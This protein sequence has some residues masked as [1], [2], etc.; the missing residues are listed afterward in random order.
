MY[1][2]AGWWVMYTDRRK[3]AC[4]ALEEDFYT[5][6]YKGWTYVADGRCEEMDA[7]ARLFNGD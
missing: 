4:V 5:F 1:R 3:R 2:V 7:M 6:K